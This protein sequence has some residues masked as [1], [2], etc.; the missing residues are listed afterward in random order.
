MYY[1]FLMTSLLNETNQ[2]QPNQTK[3][4]PAVDPNKKPSFKF[5]RTIDDFIDGS[6]LLNPSD[7]LALRKLLKLRE[8][9]GTPQVKVTVSLLARLM[10]VNRISAKRT[11]DRLIKEGF[12]FYDKSVIDPG[13]NYHK[14]VYSFPA[15]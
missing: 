6:I 5:D 1:H 2:K 7:K 14:R 9:Q 11:T 12:L 4:A 10:G 8:E 13:L 15:T 3:P